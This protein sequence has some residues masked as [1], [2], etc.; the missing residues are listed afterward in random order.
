MIFLL[1][2][3]LILLLLLA[4]IIT[5]RDILSPWVISIFMFILTVAIAVLNINSWNTDISGITFLVVIIALV[6]FGF[7]EFFGK[8]F[9]LKNKINIKCNLNNKLNLNE[10]NKK[11]I[12]SNRSFVFIIVVMIITLYFYYDYIQKIASLA[13]YHSG[14]NSMLRYARAAQFD[15]DII[16]NQSIFLNLGIIFSRVSSYFFIFIF[17]YNSIFYN[18]RLKYIKYLL[19]TLINS[20]III[21]STG[22]GQFINLIT[23]FLIIFFIMLKKKYTWSNKLNTKI[24]RYGFIGILIFLVIFRLTGYLTE[25]S[26]SYSAWNNFSMYIGAPIIALD[27]YL[28]DPPI[29]NIIFGKESFSSIYHILRILGLDLQSYPVVLEYRSWENVYN[30]NIYTSIR[31]YIQDFTMF[32]ML[33][34]QFIIGFM[35]GYFYYLIKYSNKINI[36]LILYATYFFPITQIALEERFFLKVTSIEGIYT[37]FAMLVVWYFFIARKNTKALNSKSKIS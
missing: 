20:G 5:G 18:F 24:V 23:F 33:I 19:P 3:A 15:E 10:F 37:L 27:K 25:K 1:L 2:F 26:Y 17:L 28:V 12:I 13:G 22:R 11:L 6:S 29:G 9:L 14:L 7:G 32:G 31:R 8:L 30:V 36:G 35:Y 16:T 21:L 4:Y 34:I